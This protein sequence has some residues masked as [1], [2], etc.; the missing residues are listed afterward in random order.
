VVDA[1]RQGHEKYFDPDSSQVRALPGLITKFSIMAFIFM[2]IGIPFIRFNYA[3]AAKKKNMAYSSVKA[4]L[5]F[6]TE[7]ERNIKYR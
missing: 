5:P 3:S 1:G 6:L 7:E 4:H 2:C